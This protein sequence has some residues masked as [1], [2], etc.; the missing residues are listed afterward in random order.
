MYYDI[1]ILGCL[2]DE[3]YY[4]YQIKKKLTER[5][6][7][8]TTI[9][10]NTLYSLLKQ[11][12]KMG[13]ITKTVAILAGK[14]N[15]NIYSITDEG[16]KYFVEILRDFPDSLSRNRD[17]YMMRLYYFHL[18]DIPTRVKILEMRERYLNAA[19]D[20]I[21]SLQ[22]VAAT[23]F[24]PNR[25]ELREFHLRLLQSE[26]MLIAE[27]RKKVNDPCPISDEGECYLHQ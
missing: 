25:S 4:G 18:L 14:P 26:R 13:V 6:D 21:M 11:Y 24:I 7:V 9:N 3:P 20:S 5:F 19:I 8:C 16:K 15:R 2:M 1:F 17:E 10:N 23:V 22:D 12:E 27:M